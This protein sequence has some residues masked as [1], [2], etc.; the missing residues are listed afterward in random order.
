[1]QSWFFLFFL[2]LSQLL[3]L[4]VSVFLYILNH[5]M[6]LSD[7]SFHFIDI[8]LLFLVDLGREPLRHENRLS[9]EPYS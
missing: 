8:M 7:I 4:L 9:R 1:M 5:E 2:K 3:I 6:E